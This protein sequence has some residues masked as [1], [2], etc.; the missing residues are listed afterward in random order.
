M[1]ILLHCFL[2]LFAIVGAYLA[3]Y[4][5]RRVHGVRFPIADQLIWKAT[6]PVSRFR[7]W[8]R[9]DRPLRNLI[10]QRWDAV[11]DGYVQVSQ[12]E[13]VRFKLESFESEG[14]GWFMREPQLSGGYLF[15]FT[16]RFRHEGTDYRLSL[17]PVWDEDGSMSDARLEAVV[18]RAVPDMPNAFR[19]AYR[20][21]LTRPVKTE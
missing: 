10:I 11:D 16:M 17:F 5:V 15:G 6:E 3:L 13:Y 21:T 8:Q 2:A 4:Y 18:S 1:K 9:I 19:E 14:S 7:T 12:G 20:T